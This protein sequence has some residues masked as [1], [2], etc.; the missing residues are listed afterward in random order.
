MSGEQD[1]SAGPYHQINEGN[2]VNAV[3]HGVLNLYQ[4]KPAYHIEMFTSAP[5]EMTRKQVRRRPS[6]LLLA[7]HEVVRFTGRVEE[8]ARLAQWRDDPDEGGISVLLLHGSGGQGKTRLAAEFARMSAERE[9]AVWRASA[10]PMEF[11]EQRP[12]SAPES[13]E[14]GTLLLADY[15]ERW[16]QGALHDLLGDPLL[17]RRG[18]TRVLLVAR[19]AGDWWLDVK[20]WLDDQ[21]ISADRMSLEHLSAND[22]QDNRN[23]LFERARDE[24][25]QRLGL[26]AADAATIDAPG[27]LAED[28]YGLVLRIHMAA[29]ALV[30]ARKRGV[31]APADRVRISEYLI[32][33]ERRHW[34]DVLAANPAWSSNVTP[35]I[36]G[37]AVYTAILAGPL[38]H[39]VAHAAL[40]G[41]DVTSVEHVLSAHQRCYPSEGD[42]TLEPIYPDLLAED[43]VALTTVGHK[44]DHAPDPW[45]THALTRLLSTGD[46]AQ[47]KPVLVSRA[48]TVLIEAANRWEHL[49][50]R[51]LCPILQA[52]PRI[53]LHIDNAA[54]I[55]LTQ[56]PA[57][58]IATLKAIIPVLTH[59]EGA[60]VYRAVGIAAIVRRYMT[61]KET[62]EMGDAQRA[63]N[64][65]WVARWLHAA[66]LHEDALGFEQVAVALYERLLRDAFES[67]DFRAQARH[68]ED[69]AW[70]HV[71]FGIA[72]DLTGRHGK[73]LA[74]TIEGI[75][76]HCLL[77]R[78]RDLDV[79]NSIA[80]YLETLSER[81]GMVL[82]S[83]S[84]RKIPG[85][86]L[87][88]VFDKGQLE[89]SLGRM[90]AN[91]AARRIL[92]PSQRLAWAKIAVEVNREWSEGL[93]ING[94]LELAG[95]LHN[96]ARAREDTGDLAG[97]IDS[98]REAVEIRR[99]QSKEVPGDYDAELAN[100]LHGLGRLLWKGRELA[101]GNATEAI[102]CLTEAAR[103]CTALAAANHQG[104]SPRLQRIRAELDT[105]HAAVKN[106]APG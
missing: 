81:L 32:S 19:P 88:E 49:A 47:A 14:T 44:F 95:A 23:T 83:A 55:R 79:V 71:G 22:D 11:T 85:S 102:E 87:D 106:A 45:T 75:H 42:L 105:I 100:V 84:M 25:A 12:V 48:M 6:A 52:D 89:L 60:L 30:D 70:A 69:L 39:K 62:H 33:R 78:A 77:M 51:H 15:A 17:R 37:R 58:D 27:Q 92:M 90:L 99:G 2:Q 24:Y 98:V 80:A 91:L 7:R 74:S 101:P 97:A 65:S 26:P 31:A 13:N 54:L 56:I 50:A 1:E 86:A 20:A 35:T 36:L 76:V 4:W 5:T 93:L 34:Q 57:L 46:E 64:L 94:N 68:A 40:N 29:L 28:E 16:P 61:L 10:H 9:W 53:A 82:E 38:P 66:A 67:G 41:A 43:F 18:R 72:L 21:S 73:A 104:F 96:L 8:L 59:Q 3:Q 103:L 63:E